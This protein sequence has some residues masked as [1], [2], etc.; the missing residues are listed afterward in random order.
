MELPDWLLELLEREGGSVDRRSIEG[1][2]RKAGA[3]EVTWLGFA[4]GPDSVVARGPGMDVVVDVGEAD[5]PVTTA[6]EELVTFLQD[7]GALRQLH[8][9]LQ[10]MDLVAYSARE[11][12]TARDD[13]D[14]SNPL[15]Q[16][17]QVLETGIVTMYARSFVSG[18]ARL[19]DRWLPPAGPTRDLHFRILGLRHTVYAHADWTASRTIVDT[20]AMLG[21]SGPPIFA[22]VRS[23]LSKQELHEIADLA[24]A[25]Q[26][27][28]WDAAGEMKGRLGAANSPGDA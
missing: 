21:Q 10:D 2:M 27:R 7:F 24:E 23:S 18:K 22:E 12:A 19:G 14:V 16:H 8:S 17:A 4:G 13:D 11:L 9:A 25:Q 15:L 1:R 6:L 26:A 20:N 28:F 3:S 5:K